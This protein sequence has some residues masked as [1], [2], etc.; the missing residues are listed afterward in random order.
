[1]TCHS[2][3]GFY[4]EVVQRVESLPGVRSACCSNIQ[5]LGGSE[6]GYG[7][8]KVVPLGRDPTEGLEVR[9]TGVTRDYFATMGIPLLRGRAFGT[10]DEPG[11]SVGQMSSAPRSVIIDETIARKLFGEENPVGQFLRADDSGPTLEVIGVARDV[12]HKSLRGGPRPSVYSIPAPNRRYVLS[13]FHA[14]TAGNPLAVAGAIRQVV[15]ELDPKVEVTELQ[16]MTD[17]LND[18]LFRERSLS[19]LVGFFSLL[20][21]VLAC[22]GLYGTLSY[23][24]VRRTREI[25]IRVA[26]GAQQQTVLSL[27]VRQG[28]KLVLIGI[29][30][31]LVA[32]FAMTR[33]VSSLLY[34]VTATDP[35]TFAGVSLLLIAVSLIACGLPARR[36]A[37]ID[38]MTALRCE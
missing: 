28:L 31:G 38:P 9:G 4:W 10:Q 35:A 29:G 37:A 33:L 20:A 13:Y 21:L 34:G 1:M 6:S 2:G 27:V 19:S 18:Q 26:L 22:L 12:I 8:Y 7:P 17:L 11:A 3:G 14:R 36:A 30:I 32:A 24:V 15:R 16:T 25:G 23:S 5:S